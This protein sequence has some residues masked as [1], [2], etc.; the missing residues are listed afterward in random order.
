MQNLH[1]LECPSEAFSV[2]CAPL[3]MLGGPGILHGEANPIV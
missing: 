3:S 2:P 1:L